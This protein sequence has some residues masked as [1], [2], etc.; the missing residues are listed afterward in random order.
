MSETEILRIVATILALMIAVI[1]HEVM[2]GFIAYK[3]GDS[4][5]KNAGRLSINPFIHIDPVG[6]LLIPGILFATGA[7]FILGW[8]KPV[9]VNILTV[10]RNK[11][12]RGA[13]EVALAGVTYNFILAALAT[14]IFYSLDKPTSLI[15]DFIL[16]FIIQSIIINIV[17][18][19][20]NL[21]PIP[22]LD[23]SQ[24]LKYF[25]VSMGWKSVV[26]FLEKIYPYGMLII[27]A[28]LL[29][30]P[31]SSLFFMPVRLLLNFLLPTQF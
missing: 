15:G 28:I 11:G 4:T 21:W 29:I 17:L 31:L 7:P 3:H 22:P 24:A 9:P 19:V 12:T 8:A 27:V 23:G 10:L 20:F 18:G 1:G 26:E 16:L 5:A 6:T 14:V 30:R 2:H 13:I 25:S